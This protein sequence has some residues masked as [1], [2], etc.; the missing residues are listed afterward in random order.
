[1]SNWSTVA[2]CLGCLL[3]SVLRLWL[4]MPASH[5][6]SITGWVTAAIWAALAGHERR[7]RT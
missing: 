6:L 3:L 7:S 4:D 1:M 5:F 2:M